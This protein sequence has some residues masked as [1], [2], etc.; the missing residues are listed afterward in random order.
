MK[1]LLAVAALLCALSNPSSGAKDRQPKAPVESPLERYVREVNQ[2]SHQ[3]ANAS[4][5]SLY[6]TGA[7]LADTSRDLRANQIYDL[8]TIV[9]S[10]RASAVSKGVTNTARKSSAKTSVNSLAG[11]IKA[12][13][14]LP[15]LLSLSNN[16]Q[17]QGQGTTSREST[18]T[19]TL[20]AEVAAVLPNGNLVVEGEK[21]III[22]SE[23]QTVTVRGIIR[24]DD[25][26]PVNSVQSDRLARLEV[27]VNGK[28]VVNDAVKRPFFLY[29]LLLGLLPF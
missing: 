24:P 14:A 15:N 3:D 23:R 2:R 1:P 8:V 13:A 5:G 9:V 16:Q 26:S 11:P 22:N 20:T 17:L 21:E 28:G 4:P 7:R 19:T 27:R 25:L 12:G 6:S 29:R 18:L 10:D